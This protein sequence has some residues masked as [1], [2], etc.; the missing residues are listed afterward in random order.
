M[1]KAAKRSRRQVDRSATTD[2][3]TQIE[4]AAKNPQATAIGALI[5]GVVPWFARTLAHHEVPAAWS[6]GNHGLATAMLAVV[7]GCA[8]FSALTVYK[9]GKAAFGDHRKALGFTLALEGV[10][11]V[12]SG[13]TSTA[14]LIVLIAINALANG[15][16]IAM[17]REATCKRRVAVAKSAA[18]R[19]RRSQHRTEHEPVAAAPQPRV[20]PTR[21]RVPAQRRE[22]T[23]A[24]GLVPAPRWMPVMDDVI[25]A[26]IIAEHL[27]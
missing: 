26:E 22:R 8:L 5:G 14:A 23:A 10:M 9:F 18:T 16:V 6:A 2:L 21:V 13:A 24:Q 7:L 3:V 4:C 1:R 11:L 27:S 20:A 17:A 25:D 15:S 19:A 12:S